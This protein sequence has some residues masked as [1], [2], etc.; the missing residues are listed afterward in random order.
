MRTIFVIFIL[1]GFTVFSCKK[2][3]YTGVP[4]SVKYVF[5]PGGYEAERICRTNSRDGI[6]KC[7]LSDGVYTVDDEVYLG[8]KI[9][10]RL[11]AH[12]IE[13]ARYI[14]VTLLIKGKEV[15]KAYAMEGGVSAA[16]AYTI[17]D[18]DFK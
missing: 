11:D 8:D 14:S 5:D 1:L 13:E 3:D 16:I 9:T 10:L 2:R 6:I 12:T 15:E 7:V 17:T 4:L 18:K